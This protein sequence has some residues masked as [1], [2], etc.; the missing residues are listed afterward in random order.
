MG[1]QTDP[2]NFLLITATSSL[3]KRTHKRGLDFSLHQDVSGFPSREMAESITT[4]LT[5]QFNLLQTEEKTIH[6]SITYTG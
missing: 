5:R 3:I 1:L 4:A 6:K 2:D